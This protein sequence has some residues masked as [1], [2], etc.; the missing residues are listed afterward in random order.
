MP[1]KELAWAVIGKAFKDLE[2]NPDDFDAREF[3]LG[4]ARMSSLWFSL[5]ETL[6]LTESNIEQALD[7]WR[8]NEIRSRR[9]KSQRG[10]KKFYG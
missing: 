9:E 6:P 8:Q 3:L 5:A 4:W 1:E 2:E 7:I 10:R